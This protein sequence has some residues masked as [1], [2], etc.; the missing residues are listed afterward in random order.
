M[1]VDELPSSLRPA[2]LSDWDAGRSMGRLIV[3]WQHPTLRLISPVGVLEHGP[4]GYRF[5][6]LRR[7]RELA[8]FQPFLDFPAWH[9]DYR[10]ER[11]FPLFAQRIMSPRRPDFRHFLDQLDLSPDASPW[12]QLARSGGRSEGDTLQVFP[13]PVVEADGSTACMFLVSGI[14]YCNG[15]VLPHLAVGDRLELRDEPGNSANPEAL[16]VCVAG[17]PIGWI[18]DLMIDYVRTSRRSGPVLLTV[19]HVNGSDAPAHLRVLVRLEGTVPPGYQ[20]MAG[21]GWETFVID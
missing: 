2:S 4:T 10:D 5:R 9:G 20:P 8:G 11:L 6:Y 19:V 7:A 1:S 18:P 3:A 15:G 13:A 16:H 17:Q 21:P 12:E 14:R